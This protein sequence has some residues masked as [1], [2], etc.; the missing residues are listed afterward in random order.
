MG[1]DLVRK[2]AAAVALAICAFFAF[3]PDAWIAGLLPAPWSE[4]A[5]A[6]ARIAFLIIGGG[7]AVVLWRHFRPPSR[8]PPTNDL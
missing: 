6:M 1:N 4:A 5:L 2:I 7:A 3:S 8:Q